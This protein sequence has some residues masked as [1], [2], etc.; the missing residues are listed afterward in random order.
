MSIEAIYSI[1]NADGE[2][3]S[4][5]D[6]NEKLETAGI[7]ED[8]I[9]Q[10]ST[11]IE[12]YASENKITLP[13]SDE[14]KSDAPKFNFVGSAGSAKGDFETKLVALGV[15]QDVVSQ[16]KDAVKAYAA[17]NNIQLPQ[18]PSGAK[19]NLAA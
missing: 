11:A 5:F 8:V 18:P 16:G 1:T 9:K 13:K 14:K 7:P 19:L 15:P 12:K 6:V 10:G 3:Y 17:Q 2:A 4:S